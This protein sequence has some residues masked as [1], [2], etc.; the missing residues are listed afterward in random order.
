MALR[1]RGTVYTGSTAAGPA[2]E[3]QQIEDGL[4]AL[5]GAISDVEFEADT[6]TGFPSRGVGMKDKPAA[7]RLKTRVLSREMTALSGDTVD[8]TTGKRLESGELEAIGITGTGVIGL[9]S[10]GLKAHLIRIPQITTFDKEIHLPNDLKFTEKDLLEA[11]KAIGSLRAGH[12]TL[13][14]EAG[15]Q[16]EEIETAYMSGASGTYV[17]ALKA[18]EIGMIPAKVKRIYQVGNT[19]LA[20][21]GDLV[22]DENTLW[23]MKKIADDLRQHHCMFAASK[24]FEKV[25][26]L[27]LAYW[28]EGMPLAQ[29]QKFLNKYG[30]PALQAVTAIPEIIKT[31]DRDIPDLGILGLTIIS[32]IGERRTILFEGCIG[33]GACVAAC[34]ESALGLKEV[35]GNFQLTID[36]ALCDGVSCRRCERACSQKGFDLIKIIT[37]PNSTC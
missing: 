20:M 23:E 10:Q 24:T 3:G 27:E 16:L 19:S 2:L 9:I 33:D 31:V 7:G 34:P 29:Y 22:R 15:I 25:F 4:L 6:D 30:F 14:R 35:G 1:V 5:P 17:D 12:I 13:C 18:Q 32:D 11:G 36:L 28:T 21:A 37:S 26:I 8:P